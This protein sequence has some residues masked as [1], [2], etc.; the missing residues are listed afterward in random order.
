MLQNCEYEGS[1]RG[2][3]VYKRITDHDHGGKHSSRF[4]ILNRKGVDNHNYTNISYI[5][6]EKHCNKCVYTKLDTCHT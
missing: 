1:F 5:L 3:G 6:K 2:Q 4:I